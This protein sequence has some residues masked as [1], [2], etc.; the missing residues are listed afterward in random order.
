[1]VIVMTLGF[2]YG[3]ARPPLM[4]AGRFGMHLQELTFSDNTCQMSWMRMLRPVYTAL[5]SAKNTKFQ[6]LDHGAVQEV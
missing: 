5:T 2:T 3:I 6:Q 1:M 4:R